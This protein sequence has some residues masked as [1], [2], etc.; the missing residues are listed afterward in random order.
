[1]NRAATLASL[2]F[3]LLAASP[4]SALDVTRVEPATIESLTGG[5]PMVIV[6]EE[7]AGGLKLVT[8]GVLIAAPPSVVWKVITDY[9]RYAEWMPE[10]TEVKA[11]DNGDGTKNVMYDLLFEL[12]IIRRKMNYTLLTTETGGNHIEWTL[13]EG[14]FDKSVGG[15]HL[16]PARGGKATIAWYSTFTNLKSMGRLVK[17]LLEEQPALEMAIQVSTAVTVVQ[18]LRERVENPQAAAPPAE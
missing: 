5:A 14:D 11:S 12:S 16:T 1:M 15:W 9:D 17:G 6:E 8:G 3:V 18:K 10:V 4:A 7:P 13:V 2:L